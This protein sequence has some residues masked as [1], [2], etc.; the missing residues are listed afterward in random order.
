MV[1]RFEKQITIESELNTVHSLETTPES[2]DAHTAS[3]QREIAAGRERALP[4]R[5]GVRD[6]V[7]R[8]RRPS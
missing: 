1:V 2:L 3:L 4:G 5:H 7:R 8:L 6:L